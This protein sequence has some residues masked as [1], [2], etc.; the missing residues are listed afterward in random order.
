MKQ[1]TRLTVTC[2]YPIS[3]EYIM[4]LIIDQEMVE[5]AFT[6]VAPPGYSLELYIDASVKNPPI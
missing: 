2:R 5:I 4:L 1:Q 3:K 6:L